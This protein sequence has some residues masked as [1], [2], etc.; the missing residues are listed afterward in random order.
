MKTSAEISYY[1]LSEE[2]VPPIRGFIERIN[3]YKG[4]TARTNGMSTQIFGEY[5]LL[6]EA[7]SKEIKESFK[8]PH[9]VFVM[10]IINADLDT[11][12]AK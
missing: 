8:H 9:S 11:A 10:K 2:Y 12:E 6:M 4:L 7:L 5:D 3:K 1:P